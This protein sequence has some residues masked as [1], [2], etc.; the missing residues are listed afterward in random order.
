MF[1]RGHSRVNFYADF[2]VGV[3]MKV[4]FC[5][6]EEVFDLF[7]R[8]VCRRAAAPMELDYGTILRDATADALHFLF[9]NVK[10]RRSDGFVFLDDDIASAKK[11]KAF[12]ERNVHVER[13]GRAGVLG[14]VVDA[15]EIGGTESVVPYRRGGIAGVARTGAVV[16]DEEFLADVKLAAHLLQAWMCECHVWLLIAP[17]RRV[18]H[19]ESVSSAPSR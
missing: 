7:W 11:A 8:Q 9:Q 12:A 13:D 6:T 15:F 1:A 18:L 10:V 5:E 4:L 16:F 17:V 2:G 14:L 19:V 3:K